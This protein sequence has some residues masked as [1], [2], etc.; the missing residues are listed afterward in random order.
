M[1]TN[2]SEIP[3][4]LNSI[5]CPLSEKSLTWMFTPKTMVG[6]LYENQTYKIYSKMLDMDVDLD[7]KSNYSEEKLPS[8]NFITLIPYVVHIDLYDRKF[9]IILCL[10]FLFVL[11]LLFLLLVL[12]YK[13]KIILQLYFDYVAAYHRMMK[14]EMCLYLTRYISSQRCTILLCEELG[15]FFFCSFLFGK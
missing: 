12:I 7:E 1:I 13:S 3:C 2:S 14:A 6:I 9:C 15:N 5:P 10:V 4:E 8:V 11:T